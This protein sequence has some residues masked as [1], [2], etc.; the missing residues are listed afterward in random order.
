MK[1]L[2]LLVVVLTMFACKYNEK[3]EE[4][5]SDT[6]SQIHQA[7]TKG[8]TL[9]FNKDSLNKTEALL[10]VKSIYDT[11][12]NEPSTENVADTIT[13]DD[14]SLKYFE[15]SSG[16]YYVY[17][18]ENRGPMYGVST[19]WC[20][21]FI[22]KKTNNN[23][24]LNDFRLQAGGGGMYGNSGS[25][26]ELVKIG[27]ESLGITI[28]GGQSHMGQNYNVTII[29]LSHGKL[30]KS[31]FLPIYHDYGQGAGDDYKITVCDENKY[32]F[33]KSTNN[34]N[35]DLIIDRYNCVN[36]SAVKVDSV[37]I[38]YRNGYNIPE[39]FLFEG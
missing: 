18:V 1:K 7:S 33:K 19:G 14:V 23:W 9:S 5:L 10:L 32:Y 11:V 3:S 25:L 15:N 21:V 34:K 39:R 29:E 4:K 31:F 28:S 17:V 35:Y 12:A 27:D 37:R 22:L 24:Q 26:K 38:L 6:L 16:K 8:E 20:D 36:N 2:F 13:R 30:G